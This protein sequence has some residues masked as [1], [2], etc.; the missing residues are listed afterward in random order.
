MYHRN[1]IRHRWD[2]IC[3][4]RWFDSDWSD[5]LHHFKS[6]LVAFSE[7]RG[8]ERKDEQGNGPQGDDHIEN[9]FLNFLHAWYL[10]RLW[11]LCGTVYT[12]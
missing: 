12:R 5:D 9:E 7:S 6:F 4:A 2:K 1:I 8:V 3:P 10:N 11:G